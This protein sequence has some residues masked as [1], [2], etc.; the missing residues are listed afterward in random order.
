VTKRE[1]FTTDGEV[2]TDVRPYLASALEQS[3]DARG[4]SHL[5]QQLKGSAI[6]KIAGDVRAKIAAGEDVLN[7][8]VG[9]FAPSEFP[10]PELL[11]DSVVEALQA[12]QSNYP[13]ATGVLECRE[14]VRDMYARRLGLDYPVDSVLIAGGARPFIAGA[15]LALVNPGDK[16]VF[17]LP[18]WNNA[19]YC[20]ISGAQ[21]VALPTTPENN[22]F[23][24]NEDLIGHLADA[25]MLVLNTPQNPTG[26]VMEKDVLRQICEVVVAENQRRSKDGRPALYVL[27]DQIYWMLTFDGVEH[28]D[29]V[30]V[31]PEMAPYT[32]FVDG[33]SKGFAATGLRVGWAVAAPDVIRKMGAILSHMGAW[34]P[35]PEQLGT[36]AL[37]RDDA[38]VDAYLATTRREVLA[39]LGVLSETMKTLEAEGYDVTCIP[40]QGAIYLSMR[41]NLQG[42]RTTSGEVLENDEHVRRFLLEEAGV[43]LIPFSC[44]GVEG[45]I[46]WFRA[47]VGAVSLAQCESI[48]GRLRRAF[49]KLS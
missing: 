5:A 46:G 25:R 47:S 32:V 4:L 17:G 34:A 8:T 30:S 37:L 22:F 49:S 39:R 3:E 7:L 15:Y 10:I 16:V 41:L 19:Y 48:A 12:G 6:L 24:N 1:K 21:P 27:Y 26:T 18:S 44:F 35:K 31:M 45:D 42:K 23:V 2:S 40:P 14:A 36:A 13:P 20:T 29:P 43:A 9:D 38:A 11:R 33:I 28:Y